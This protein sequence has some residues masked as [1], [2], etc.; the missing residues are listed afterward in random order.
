MLRRVCVVSGGF[1][2]F[3]IVGGA[4][5]AVRY[6]FSKAGVSLMQDSLPIGMVHLGLAGFCG[7][8]FVGIFAHRKA[9]LL[10]L[11]VYFLFV[12]YSVFIFLLFPAVW[13][14]C[15]SHRMWLLGE[16]LVFVTV[17]LAS[18]AG[19]LVGGRLRSKPALSR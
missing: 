2:V 1:I 4:L 16:V 5:G 17:P 18:C 15:A 7:G 6:H 8:V 11:G 9:W 19:A 12:V 3:L 10:S 14:M 13:S